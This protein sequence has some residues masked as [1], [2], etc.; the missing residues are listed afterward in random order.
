MLNETRKGSTTSLKYCLV[1]ELMLGSF[2]KITGTWC[3]VNIGR[4]FWNLCQIGHEIKCRV[5]FLKAN[6]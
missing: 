5:K 3:G 1:M 4:H 6:F 2:L